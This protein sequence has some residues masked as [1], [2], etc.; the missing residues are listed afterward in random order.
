MEA[1]E[2]EVTMAAS[3][4]M[5]GARRR[6]AARFSS[7][8]STKNSVASAMAARTSGDMRELPYRES[9]SN[10]PITGFTPNMRV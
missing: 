3:V 4:R 8:R 10:A 7:S 2:Q 6:P 5:I 9:V 1:K